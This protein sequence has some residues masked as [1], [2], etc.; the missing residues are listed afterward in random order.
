MNNTIT[1]QVIG[2]LIPGD[3]DDW[4]ESTEIAIP[5]FDDKKMIIIFSGLESET[6]KQFIEDADKALKSFLNLNYKNRLAI[7]PFAYKNCMDF[8][9]LVGFDQVDEKLRGIKKEEEIWDFINPTEIFVS[10]SGNIEDK[11]MYVQV[12]CSCGWDEEH[13]L[14]FVFQQGEKLSKVSSQDGHLT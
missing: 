14:Q 10:R 11:N 8:L 1:S 13:G 5:F 12:T 3:C 9:N 2:Q 7:S 6:D 4:W